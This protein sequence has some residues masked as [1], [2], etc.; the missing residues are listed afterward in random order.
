[1]ENIRLLYIEDDPLQRQEIIAQLQQKNFSVTAAEDGRKGLQEFK[2]GK[3][4]VVLCDLNM[5]EMDGME[6]LHHIKQSGREIPVFLLTARGT[7]SHAVDAMEKGA[8]YFFLKPVDIEQVSLRIR[9]AVENRTVQKRLEQSQKTLRMIMD[10][11]P[12]IIYS[13]NPQGE[14]ISLNPAVKNTLGYKPEELLGQSVFNIIYPADR[15]RILDGFRHSVSQ[16]ED[17]IKTMQFRM[18]TKEGKLKDFE[19]SRQLFFED[20]EVVRNDGIARDITERKQ[21]EQKL[22]RTN[23]RLSDKARQLE[24]ASYQLGKANVSML[25]VQEELKSKNIEMEELLNT[26]SRNQTVLQSILD[27]SFSVIIMVDH[28]GKVIA[29]NKQMEKFFGIA[30][31]EALSKSFDG[32]IRQIKNNFHEPAVF[33]QEIDRFRNP[34][35]ERKEISEEV[36]NVFDRALKLKGPAARYL[37]VFALAVDDKNGEPLGHAWSFMDITKFKETDEKLRAI[38]EASPIPFIISREKDGKILYANEPLGQLVGLKAQQL[39][40]KCTPDFYAN[41]EDRQIVLKQLKENGSVKNHEV[42]IRRGDGS[43]IWM[44]MSLV[45]NEINGEPV[46]IGAMYDINERHRAEEALR[47][48]RNFVSAVLDTAGALVVVLDD[49]GRVIRF[50]RACEKL[51]GRR[52]DEVAGETIWDKFLLPE[53]KEEVKAGFSKLSG[54]HFPYDMENYWIA[55]NGDHRLISW[56]NTALLDESGKVEY[57]IATGIDITERRRAHEKLHLYRQ[58]FLNSNDGIA[59]F[60]PDGNFIE[61]NPAH[62]RYTGFQDQE[63]RGKNI[64]DLMGRETAKPIA[65]TLT[66]SGSFRGELHTISKDGG[67]FDIDLSI[68]SILKSS[69]EV[70]CYVGIARDITE[71]KKAETALRQAHDHLEKRVDER[72]HELAELNRTLQEEVNER[73]TTEE[74]L[75]ESEQQNRA[76]L[77]AIPDLMFRL[78]REGRYL[79]YQAPKGSKLAVEPHEVV[80]KS[81][82]DTLPPGLA[83]KT[84]RAVE[85]LLASGDM[86]IFEYQLSHDQQMHDF[87]ARLVKSGPE[88]VLAI[89]RDITEQKQAREALQRAHDELEKRVRERTAELAMVNDSLREQIKERLQAEKMLEN[90]LASEEGLAKSSQALLRQEN[91]QAALHEALKSLLESTKAGR[92]YIFENFEDEEEGLCMRQIAE[93]CAPDVSSQ[94][95]NPLLQKVPYQPGFDR[96]E[97]NLSSG[98]PI[99]GL[100]RQFPKHESQLLQEQDIQSILVLPVRVDDKWFGFIGFDD[101]AQEREWSEQDIRLLKTASEMIGGY[102]SRKQAE[103]ALQVSETR[104]RSLVENARDI[105]YSM[106]PDGKFSYLSPQFTN[107]T[108]Y[109][110]EEFEGKT[111]EPL[112]VNDKP[113]M[114]E[115]RPGSGSEG[116][117]HEYQIRHRDGSLRWFVSNSTDI[118]DDQQQII[119][120][121]GIAHDVTEMKTVLENLERTNRE[122]RSTQAQLVQ[123]EKMASLGML[124]AGIAHEI[125]TPVGAVSSM[126]NTLVRALVKLRNALGEEDPD[127]L[128]A[129]RIQS[130]MTIIEDANKVIESGTGR[131]RM[132]VNRLRSFARLDEAELKDADI[133]EGLEDT[134]TLVHHELKHQIE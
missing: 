3:F 116:E 113:L 27:L 71:R 89:V 83:D 79:D 125:N 40:N 112:I 120:K 107:Y 77:S 34:L 49:K 66:S 108:G 95:E 110:P 126:H 64:M 122:L 127:F 16:G 15:D 41:P 98:K 131:V 32:I 50:N 109:R 63:L 74:A 33:Q 14:F 44:I 133:H 75:R 130:L 114:P 78:S 69:G 117:S 18:V 10:N 47:R 48:E 80:G 67:H 99:A 7:I 20:G 46:V 94:M 92:A 129:D 132:I 82:D 54:G 42:R 62:L 8:G 60:D 61:R 57:V 105:I 134:L 4:E 72:T 2:T 35:E 1:M 73:R 53:E 90:R 45:T 5:P 101:I 118:R 36:A 30:P 121:I 59:V 91:P 81:L 86:Q 39:I 97:K 9:Q 13:L 6:V 43:V 106:K 28:E 84:R 102:L 11:V 22:T 68:F 70:Q 51:T 96:W 23:L 119:E 38:V 88:E 100:V 124:V 55:G 128:K 65:K 87:E 29:T 37:S 123:S 56:S 26:I 76:L 93:V 52:A 115:S 21:M 31:E 104:F 111:L 17:G 58:I 12:D 85:K 25:A 24:E 103:N 19:I